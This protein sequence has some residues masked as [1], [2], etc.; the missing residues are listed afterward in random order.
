M[1]KGLGLMTLAEGVETREQLRMLQN[2][3]CDQFQGHL[4]GR[5]MPA[6]DFGFLLRGV[7]AT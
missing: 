2:L 1:A 7:A 3:G 4:L 5:P 6:E